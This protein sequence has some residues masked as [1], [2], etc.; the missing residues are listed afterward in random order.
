V[1]GRVKEF[2]RKPLVRKWLPPELNE[3]AKPLLPEASFIVA[4]RRREA[5]RRLLE[6]MSRSGTFYRN[7]VAPGET[8]WLRKRQPDGIG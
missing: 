8:V 6:E 4:E 3:T 2:P 1:T 5:F 7:D